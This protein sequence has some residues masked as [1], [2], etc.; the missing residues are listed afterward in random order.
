MQDKLTF[1]SVVKALKDLEVSVDLTC[2]PASIETPFALQLTALVSKIEREGNGAITVLKGKGDGILDR[3]GLNLGFRG[4]TYITYLALPEG[5]EA[6]PFFEA[7]IDIGKG[8][9]GSDSDLARQI[10]EIGRPAEL[11]V[12]IASTCPHCPGAVRTANRVAILGTKVTTSIIDVQQFPELGERFSV[13]SVPMTVLDGGLSLTGVVKAE[14]L[15]EHILSRDSEGFETQVFQSMIEEGRL[16]EAKAQIENGIGA[17]HFLTIWKTSTTALR[18]G[19]MMLAEETLAGDAAA[20]DGIGPG[21]F[22]LLRSED[23]AMR[24]DTV[25]LLSQIGLKSAIKEIEKLL[26]DPNPDVAEIAEE[27]LEEIK[28]RLDK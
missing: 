5:P 23:A 26:N 6:Q 9:T 8:A 2:H 22:P 11:L 4:Q 25:D 21:L 15:V 7:L 10:S 3:P 14:E 12:F 19:L 16:D 18:I 27:A 24:G 20:L 28:S 13:K 17:A 1:N